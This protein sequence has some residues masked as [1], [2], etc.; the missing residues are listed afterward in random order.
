M[1][2]KCDAFVQNVKYTICMHADNLDAGLTCSMTIMYCLTA[3]ISFKH[4]GISVR[5]QFKIDG[6]PHTQ[7]TIGIC[8]RIYTL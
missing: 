4:L 8:I 1:E 3:I 2:V 5:E 7:F 6:L